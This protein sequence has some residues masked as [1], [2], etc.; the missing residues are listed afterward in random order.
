MP[1]KSPAPERRRNTRRLAALWLPLLAVIGL[2][3]APAQAT[4]APALPQAATAG[5]GPVGWDT[6]RSLDGLAR[7]R[8]GEQLKQFSSF[9]RAGG[10]DDGFEGTYSCLRNET[11]GRC[12]LA[13]AAGPGEIS[14]MWFTYSPDSIAAIGAIT[15]EIDGEVVLEGSLQDIVNG[16]KGAPFVWPL[17]G[18]SA[19]TMGGSV[20]KV[21]MPYTKSMRVTTQNNPHFYHVTYRQ[22]ADAEGVTA[23]DPADQATD[24]VEGMRGYGVWD[25][26]PA[27]QGAEAQ[28]TDLAI[29]A[30]ANQ[31]VP[32]TAGPRSISELRLRLPQV[33]TSPQVYD[34]GRAYGPGGSGFS[35][36]VAENNEGVRITRR[37]DPKIAD[38][39]ATVAVEGQPA[40]EWTHG[41]SVPEAWADQAIEVAP[42][43]T[44]GK[45]RIRV[46][47]AFVSSSL[48]VNEF[49]YDVHSKVGG[50]WIRT[51]VLDVGPN[52]ANEE[53]AHEYTIGG[54]RWEGLGVFRYPVDPAAVTTSDAIL[55]GL[56]LRITFDGQTTVDSPIGEFFGSGLGKYESRTLTHSIDT[57]ENGAFTSWWPM[58]YAEN[59]VVELVNESGVEIT[60]GSLTL[61]SAPDASLP[62]ALAPGGPLGHFH[63]THDRG[64][65]VQGEEWKFLA[66]EGKG[67]FYG[68]SASMR[69]KMPA[70][71]NQLAF[72]EGDE[73]VYVDGSKSPSV[74][75]TGSED[76]YESGWYFMDAEAGS[77]EAVPYAM[78]L[79]GAVGSESEADGCAQRCLGAYR[80]MIADAV[81]FGSGIE[82]DIEHGPDSDIAA[83]YGST[84]FWYGQ[85][86]PNVTE[87][88]AIDLGDDA[89]RTEHG[90]QAAGETRGTLESTFEG[91]GDRT[92][93]A[94][95]TSSATGAV[96]FTAAVS[97]DNDGL[98][99]H[100]VSDQGEAFQRAAVFVDDQPA[101]E[102]YQPLGNASS[103]WLED[104]F[105]V[106]AALTK[107]KS[108][109]TVRVE[110]VGGAPAWSASSYRM[111]SLNGPV[112]AEAADRD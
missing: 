26:K 110:P 77:R 61:T 104:A 65:A 83:D 37:Y 112:A 84:S 106:P 72:L 28:A 36:A 89:S 100:R 2:V 12:V 78:P 50:E 48:D 11:D 79:A 73:R 44:A 68:V 103:R 92:P 76:F 16:A 80:L 47:N 38:Q 45:S 55:E 32:V 57:T 30:G 75:G 97:E 58:P 95:A 6:Y 109:V 74:I 99:L 96:S 22:F 40:G 10:N 21:P 13:E 4:G 81:P 91:K 53:A 64:D 107:G 34:D 27:A 25:P 49:R 69:G 24:V 54:Q 31:S 23:F 51:D 66:A 108:G 19:D 15:V 20:I 60:G 52:H 46:E 82:F 94:G 93:V 105:D 98:R 33:V 29:A 102:W 8:P 14:T 111:L 88:D 7:M 18:N 41:A 87:T 71:V 17:V 101:G 85:S 86:T 67:V 42:A 3:I 59:A 9:D 43:V 1:R 70:E 90:Y 35:A 63:A 62:G 56:R 5:K 39:R